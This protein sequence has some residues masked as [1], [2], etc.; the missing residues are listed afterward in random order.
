MFSII[1]INLAGKKRGA[2]SMK[3]IF[4][5]LS[6][7]SRAKPFCLSPWQASCIKS[8]VSLGEQQ[9]MSL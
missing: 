4:R 7:V 2:R 5:V 3:I 1:Q 8:G 9:V 6:H